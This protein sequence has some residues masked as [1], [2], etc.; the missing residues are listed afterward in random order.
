MP[1]MGLLVHTQMYTK[2]A[3]SESLELELLHALDNIT[4]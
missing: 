4:L 2:V 1:P 3:A